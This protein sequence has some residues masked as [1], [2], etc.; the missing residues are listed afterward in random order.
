MISFRP[1]DFTRVFGIP[2]AAQGGKKIDNKPKKMDKERKL[3]LVELVCG[4]LAQHKTDSLIDISRVRGLRKS[5]IREGHWRCL[6][7]VIKS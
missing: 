7:D 3:Q 4:E 5:D 2:G 1:T 6:M